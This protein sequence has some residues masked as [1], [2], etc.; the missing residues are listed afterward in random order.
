M[1]QIYFPFCHLSFNT[2]YDIF[3]C[4][5]GFNFHVVKFV[6]LFLYSSRFY[7]VRMPSLVILTYPP[8]NTFIALLYP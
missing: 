6:S 5:K 8:S 7:F 3:C 1:L 4:T 2:A